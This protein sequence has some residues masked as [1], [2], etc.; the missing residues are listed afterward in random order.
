[1]KRLL[2]LPVAVM[3]ALT[4]CQRGD[5]NEPLK[6]T[7]RLFNFNYRVATARYNVDFAFQGK[8]PEG[9]VV[10]A[11]FENPAGGD[12]LRV[13][14]AI[15][16]F[17]DKLWLESPPLRCVVKDRPYKVEVHLIGPD[18]RNIQTIETTVTSSLDQSV[19]PE[20][21]LV[22]G[23]AYDPNPKVFVKGGVPDYGTQAGCP[24]A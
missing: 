22:V 1:M 11:Y 17:W 4:G 14:Q 16:P 2:I 20:H 15:F 12:P 24:G 21:P 23:P 10:E 5:E 3:L 8:I 9:S 18:K 7:G 6:L 19:L 13:T